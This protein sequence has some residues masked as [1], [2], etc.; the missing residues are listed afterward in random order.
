MLVP[1][2]GRYFA[3][4]AQTRKNIFPWFGSGQKHFLL[5]TDPTGKIY[6]QQISR[7]WGL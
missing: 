3:N 4:I 5:V 7:F 1:E 2:V 6:L